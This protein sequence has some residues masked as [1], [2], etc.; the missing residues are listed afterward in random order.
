MPARS[1]TKSSV[2]SPSWTRCSNS[3]SRR[4]K[5]SRRCSISVTSWPHEISVRV[6]LAPTFPP[7]A[8]RTYIELGGR[9]RSGRISHD[10]AAS[11]STE[12][13]FEVGQT[14]RRPSVE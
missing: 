6:T 3:S 10:R 8:T 5:R 4:S 2:A 13:A 1:S 14:M 12:I 9:G 11:I 7:P